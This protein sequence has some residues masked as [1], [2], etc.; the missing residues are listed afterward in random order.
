MKPAH[1]MFKLTEYSKE[2][3]NTDINEWS[4]KVLEQIEDILVKQ[5]QSGMYEWTVNVYFI[6]GQLL[7]AK[8]HRTAIHK[9]VF[10]KLVKAGYLCHEM[11]SEKVKI[12]WNKLN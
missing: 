7:I 9:E 10:N 3:Y 6:Q 5:A 8:E 1:E 11:D 12:S 4:N 2:K